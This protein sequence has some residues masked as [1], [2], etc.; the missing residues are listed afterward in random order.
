MENVSFS[1]EDGVR[2]SG[3]FWP[4]VG[5]MGIV[6][7]HMM[8]ATK[9]SWSG[10]ALRLQAEGFDVLAIDLRGH[11]ESTATKSG[12][13]LDYK[14]FSDEEHQES[15]MD[16][17]AAFKFMLKR[18]LE[19]ET[20]FVGGAS[21]GA[22][23][24]LKYMADHHECRAGFMLSPGVD[25]HG[26]EGAEFARELDGEQRIYVAAAKDDKDAA[27]GAEEIVSAASSE[28]ESKIVEEGGHGT[29]LL[30]THPEIAEEIIQFLVTDHQ[31]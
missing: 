21:I 18:E 11:G 3:N 9:E 24:A 20:I 16:V 26:L 19:P 25:Y 30:S 15:I 28:K 14:G 17:D 1:T 8:P 27:L 10:F 13:H 7:L 5:E 23:L 2:I 6:L 31:I 12:V 4:G 22:N 29:N